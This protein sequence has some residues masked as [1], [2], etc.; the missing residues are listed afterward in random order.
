M[1]QDPAGTNGRSR[2]ARALRAMVATPMPLRLMARSPKPV[3][4]R[5]AT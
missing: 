2:K 1:V 3:R 4:K 5:A